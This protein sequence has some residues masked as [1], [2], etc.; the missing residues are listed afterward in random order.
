MSE[1]PSIWS[2]NLGASSKADAALWN[3]FAELKGRKLNFSVEDGGYRKAWMDY[4]VKFG[5]DV[6]PVGKTGIRIGKVL[7]A[8]EA[9]RQADEALWAKYPE[10]NRRLVPPDDPADG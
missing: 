4:Y 9:S 10:L 3:E 1:D 7:F 8:N 5:G 2:L 6:F